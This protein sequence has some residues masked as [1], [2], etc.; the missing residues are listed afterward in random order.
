MPYSKSVTYVYHNKK[1]KRCACACV[2]SMHTIS[3][4]IYCV[5]AHCVCIVYEHW[6]AARTYVQ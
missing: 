6:A 3:K 2:H 4:C 5:W 1:Y